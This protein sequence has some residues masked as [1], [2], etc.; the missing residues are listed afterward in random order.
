MIWPAIFFPLLLVA[1]V[2]LVDFV[3]DAPRRVRRTAYVGLGLLV[4]SV[5]AEITSAFL[6]REYG[7]GSW[8]FEVEVAL[9]EGAEVAGWLLIAFALASVAFAQIAAARD[10][11]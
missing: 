5:L 9:E 8:Q 4:F 2:L 1:F 3:R 7:N 6:R 10:S 11:G